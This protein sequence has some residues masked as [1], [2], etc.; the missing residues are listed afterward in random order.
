MDKPQFMGSDYQ[1]SRLTPAHSGPLHPTR[2]HRLKLSQ[3]RQTMPLSEDRGLK[4]QAHRDISHLSHK[5]STR[6]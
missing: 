5:R 4:D 1:T 2:P 3:P 6:V